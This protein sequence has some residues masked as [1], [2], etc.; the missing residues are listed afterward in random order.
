[1]MQAP[2]LILLCLNLAD[3]IQCASR[4]LFGSVFSMTCSRTYSCQTV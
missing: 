1:M 3:T 2:T 4:A